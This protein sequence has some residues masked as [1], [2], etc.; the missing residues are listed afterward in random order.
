[1]FKSVRIKTPSINYEMTFFEFHLARLK[2]S[3]ASVHPWLYR[4]YRSG[5]IDDLREKV[6]E[7]VQ[8]QA[9][10]EEMPIQGLSCGSFLFAIENRLV[11]ELTDE[12]TR[13]KLL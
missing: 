11:D 8:I 9:M 13:L 4:A 7:Q 3:I 1:M 2:R 10:I 6:Q 12:F 5:A